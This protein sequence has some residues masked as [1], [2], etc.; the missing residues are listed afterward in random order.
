[1]HFLIGMHIHAPGWLKSITI[2]AQRAT[3]AAHERVLIALPHVIKW[4]KQELGQSNKVG[5]ESSVRARACMH[6]KGK[7]KK[8]KDMP[9]M[10]TSTAVIST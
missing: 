9:N 2:Y 8:A 5:E 10:Y 3:M 4:W 6:D 1:M 7:Y